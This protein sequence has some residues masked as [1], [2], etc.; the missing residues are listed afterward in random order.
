MTNK[1]THTCIQHICALMIASTSAT[2][3]VTQV[4]PQVHLLVQPQIP[5]PCLSLLR[6]LSASLG[7]P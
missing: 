7:P 1:Y 2:T 4:E 3:G 5:P 6:S